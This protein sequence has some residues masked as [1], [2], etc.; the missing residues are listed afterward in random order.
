MGPRELFYADIFA[1]RETRLPLAAGHAG[2]ARPAR[3]LR[4]R[5]PASSTTCSTSCCCR[6]PT[7]TRTR[8]GTGP[9]AQVASI[10][11]ADR[12]I[13]RLV[14][15]AGG[16]D[17]FL[18]E[19][20][21]IVVA[22]H[23]HA[24]VERRIDLD[25]ASRDCHVL[26]PG[27]AAVR[28]GRDRALPDA[29]RRRWSTCWS[30]R[31][32]RDA[33]VPRIVARSLAL[34]GRRARGLRAGRR[35]RARGA[36][37]RRA[38]L[39]ARRRRRRPA[40]RALDGR[41]RPRGARR[42]ASRTGARL[43]RATRTRSPR[44]WAALA[45]PDRRATSCC[46]RGAGVRVPRLGRGRPRRRRQPR[47]AAPQ[48]LARRAALLRHRA[49][50]RRRRVGAF[51]RRAAA[52]SSALRPTLAGDDERR[53]A[54]TAACGTDCATPQLVQLVRFGVVGAS[55]YVVNLASSR[56]CRRRRRRA[57]ARARSGGLD[58]SAVGGDATT[59]R[60]DADA[61]RRRHVVRAI[62]AGRPPPLA[63]A[64][65]Q[66]GAWRSPTPRRSPAGA[67][68]DHRGLLPRGLLE[69][70]RRAGRS[71]Y[72]SRDRPPQGDRA[73][74]RR[75][76]ARARRSRQWTG[77]QVAWT[78]ARG[79]PGAFGAQGQRAV[80]LDPAVRAVP[81]CRSSTWRRPLSLLHLDLLVLLA[82]LGLARVLQRR[83][84]RRHR[85]R[86]SIRRCCTCWCAC[87]W[88]ARAAAPAA[89]RS[90][91]APARA[92]RRGWP[93]ASVFLLGFRIGL[94]VDRLQRDRRR[95]RGRDRR[96][97]AIAT[98]SRSTATSR[99]TTSTATRTARSTTRP[100]SRSSRLL[101]WSGTLGRPARR[102]RGGDRRSTC[103][104]AR[105]CSCSGAG[106]AGRRSGSRSPT[107]GRP[108]RSRST[109]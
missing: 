15:R 43:A 27:G 18:D 89:R 24:A 93:S 87:C 11:A 88:I 19:H 105:C 16:T 8:T 1:S 98:A 84:D 48:R 83:A 36:G 54:C 17:A 6:C 4:R 35:G 25:A 44:C 42:R 68:A 3:R 73:G 22:D 39:R 23:S 75:R 107:R 92:G 65:R 80:D 52:A 72:F 40:R 55:G 99:P 78:M 108:S 76:P 41:G 28:R 66:P 53:A 77:F 46:Q 57:A 31:A 69:G 59:P 14:R 102:A 64:L 85:R 79:Y 38:A 74:P 47:L 63:P 5:L 109:R 7:T 58:R 91:A 30:T 90:A 13:E 61:T 10:A 82:L 29:A 51:G 97:P 86:S 56:S 94:N 62:A 26:A 100:T 34:D 71:R 106:C 2:H 20:A 12:Q 103:C 9:H 101:P 70:Q 81:R 95:L 104:A 21:V 50:E 32:R 67:L 37:A 33:L 45:L 60:G 96:R 49:P